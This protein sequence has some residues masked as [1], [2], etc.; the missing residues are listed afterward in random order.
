MSQSIHS[1]EDEHK[2]LNGGGS[3]SLLDE[4]LT[5]EQ[6]AA[7]LGNSPRTIARWRRM[8]TGPATTWIG[9]RPYTKRSTARQWLT[10]QERRR[11]SSP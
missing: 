1:G 9:R 3:N 4:Y 2:S 7:E 5:D 10:T 6:L 8:G 11:S